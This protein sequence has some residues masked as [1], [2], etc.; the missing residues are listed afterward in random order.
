MPVVLGGSP[1]ALKYI[2]LLSLQVLSPFM[3]NLL[4]LFQSGL[5]SAHGVF[6]QLV[7]DGG[8]QLILCC[9]AVQLVFHVFLLCAPHGPGLKIRFT[10]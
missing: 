9:C 1:E 3:L 8:V 6:E 2:C 7:W 10:V 5:L 4:E